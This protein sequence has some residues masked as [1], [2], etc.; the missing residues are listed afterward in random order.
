MTIRHLVLL[1][2][3]PNITEREIA[4][5]AAA[6]KSCCEKIKNSNFGCFCKYNSS[7]TDNSFTHY[8]F[9]DFKDSEARDNYLHDPEHKRIAQEMIVP[10]LASFPEGVLV[11]DYEKSEKQPSSYVERPTTNQL[12]A[13][14]FYA[15]FKNNDVS[16]QI[17]SHLHVI[18][19]DPYKAKQNCTVE[20]LSQGF[21]G[22]YIVK[23]KIPLDIEGTLVFEKNHVRHS[24]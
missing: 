8:F 22:A 9:I 20:T 1:A 10:K 24:L 2:F 21:T 3:R 14:E 13:Q 19:A 17:S 6:L 7:S 11:F 5:I 18:N 4:Q 15:F 12:K 23:T 16:A